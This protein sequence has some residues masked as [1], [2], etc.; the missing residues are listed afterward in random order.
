MVGVILAV[1]SYRCLLFLAKLNKQPCETEEDLHAIRFS[2]ASSQITLLIGAV[3][4][5]G[6]PYL[7][8]GYRSPWLA[9]GSLAAFVLRLIYFSA[10]GR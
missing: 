6:A 9:C 2:S 3:W 7:R 5:V 10:K 8:E 1:T 4:M